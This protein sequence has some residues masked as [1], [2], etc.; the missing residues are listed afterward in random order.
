MSFLPNH[1][2]DLQRTWVVTWFAQS[3][4]VMILWGFHSN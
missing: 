4:P 1:F 3:I 2:T